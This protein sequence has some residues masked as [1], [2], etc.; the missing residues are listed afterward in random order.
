MSSAAKRPQTPARGDTAAPRQSARAVEHRN[1]VTLTGQLA[2][3]AESRLLPSGDELVLFRLV[4]PRAERAS[5]TAQ[6]PRPPSVDTLDCVAWRADVRRTAR[7]WTA[8]DIVSVEGQ[9]RRR[10]WRSP[11]G[12]GSRTEVEV[13]RAR[14]VQRAGG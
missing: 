6:R 7:G 11:S 4:V 13:H 5:R 8:G 1:E 14:R 2:A 10:F 9:L 12:P 3:T